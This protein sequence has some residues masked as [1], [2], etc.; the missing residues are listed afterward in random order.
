MEQAALLLVVG[1]LVV[2]WCFVDAVVKPITC[3][4]SRRCLSSSL[5][6]NE[7]VGG[8]VR[9]YYEDIFGGKE[10]RGGSQD[11]P[12]AVR[13]CIFAPMVFLFAG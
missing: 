9:I 2:A 4:S 12:L 10:G 1:G 13:W 8:E 3:K 7:I 5:V 11:I 6:T